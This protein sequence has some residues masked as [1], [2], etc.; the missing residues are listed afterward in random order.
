M[1]GFLATE[2]EHTNAER[3][4]IEEQC[5]H[6]T[7]AWQRS[8]NGYSHELT[9]WLP[10]SFIRSITPARQCNNYTNWCAKVFCTVAR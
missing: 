5:A 4:A 8:L 3:T 10:S 1:W 6:I 7:I 9:H 2:P